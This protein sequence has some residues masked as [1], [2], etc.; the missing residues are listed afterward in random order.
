MQSG[1]PVESMAQSNMVLILCG[2]WIILKHEAAN[3]I[4][5]IFQESIIAQ[6]HFLS[7]LRHFITLFSL[8]FNIFHQ[9]H[10]KRTKISAVVTSCRGMSWNPHSSPRNHG[11]NPFKITRQ[12][13]LPIQVCLKAMA[14]SYIRSPFS[15]IPPQKNR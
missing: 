7:S 3:S 5:I 14:F 8:I 1:G 6:I 15:Q 2:K 13:A 9:N 10:E 12:I 11:G 4:F